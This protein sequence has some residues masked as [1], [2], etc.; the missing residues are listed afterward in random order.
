MAVD[1]YT[2]MGINVGPML[3]AIENYRTRDLEITDKNPHN[4]RR[5]R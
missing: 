1:K 5:S 4:H 3:L 2:I